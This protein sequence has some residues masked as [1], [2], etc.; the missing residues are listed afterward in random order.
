[1]I[2][3]AIISALTGIV[4][5]AYLLPPRTTSHRTGPLDQLDLRDVPT[6]A[7]PPDPPRELVAVLGLPSAPPAEYFCSV[8]VSSD[9]RYL[10]SGTRSGEVWLWEVP[11]LRKLWQC[12]AHVGTVTAVAFSPDGET[13]ASGGRDGSVRRWSLSGESLGDDLPAH[14]SCVSA[15]TFSPDGR[16]LATATEGC[17]RLWDLRN[18]R[19]A[20]RRQFDIPDTPVHALAI[21]P[22]GE[23]LACA[24]G[25]DNAIRVWGLDRTRPDRDNILPKQGDFRVRALAFT[26]D[27]LG[28][29]SFDSDGLGILWDEKGRPIRSWRVFSPPCLGAIFATDGRHLITVHGDGT[30]WVLRPAGGW[31]GE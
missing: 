8:A 10:A 23:L 13:I 22:D 21:S 6:A 18:D 12:S 3:L 2:T 9:G 4:L 30:A 24:G 25:G 15:L 5:A 7:R 1:L 17:V 19:P 27:N 14:G 28:I 11:S 16:T 29:A 20:L 31:E 26:R